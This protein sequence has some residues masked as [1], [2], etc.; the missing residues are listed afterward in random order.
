VGDNPARVGLEERP[1]L[2]HRAEEALRSALELDPK[3]DEAALRLARVC[4]VTGRH[5]DAAN[6]LRRI[7]STLNRAELRYYAALFVGRSE[8]ALGREPEA[9]AAFERARELF[10]AAQSPY[11][12]LAG[13]SWRAADSAAATGAIRALPDARRMTSTFDPWWMYD[14][15][16]ADSL[17]DRLAAARVAFDAFLK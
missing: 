15:S 6:L 12:A 8:E 1:V 10:P 9:R 2:L 16:P 13:V 4:Q 14:V 7:E 11:L 5:E 3:L 17:L